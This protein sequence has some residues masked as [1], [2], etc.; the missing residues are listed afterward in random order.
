MDAGNYPIKEV[1]F[2]LIAGTE[3][4]RCSVCNAEWIPGILYWAIRTGKA[5]TSQCDHGLTTLGKIPANQCPGCRGYEGDY[6][7]A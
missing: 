6:G 1:R 7:R 2:D 5:D 4:V 3:R